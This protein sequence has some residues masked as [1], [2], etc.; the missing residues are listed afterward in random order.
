MEGTFQRL[1]SD[2]ASNWQH[3]YN[4]YPETKLHNRR[5]NSDIFSVSLN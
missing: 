5:Q 4:Y 1:R 2:A 3:D